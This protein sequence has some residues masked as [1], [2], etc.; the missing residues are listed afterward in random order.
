MTETT[1][2]PLPHGLVLGRPKGEQLQEILEAHI[3]GLSPGDLLPSERA[4]SQH[5]GVARMTV[6]QEIER[7]A[8]KGLVHRVHG[9]GTFVAEPKFEQ[10]ARLTSFTEDMRA[11]GMKPGSSVLD[12]SVLPANEFVAD[13]LEI[14]A[15]TS[16]VKID[17][18]RTA[19]GE[20]MAFERAYLPAARFPG[21]EREDLGGRSLYEL[22]RERWDI[23]VESAD[24]IVTGVT[25]NA[26]EADLLGASEH[27]P[28]FLI[29][30]TTRDRGGRVIEYVRSLYRADRYDIHIALKR[31]GGSSWSSS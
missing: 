4:L 26:E 31:E 5:Y 27:Q 2:A 9:K 16:V 25:L 29:Q 19:D 1:P 12:R 11:R 22:L 15:N 30:R 18:V 6:R 28:A 21:L 17:R 7:L 13:H 10:S 14:E 23:S 20:P 24:Q 3:A 8:A